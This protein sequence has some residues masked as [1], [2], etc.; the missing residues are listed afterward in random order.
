M[1]VYKQWTTK[2]A[3]IKFFFFFF[4]KMTLFNLY[5]VQ[6][7]KLGVPSHNREAWPGYDFS[8]NRR[9]TLRLLHNYL[10]YYYR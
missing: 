4:K 6:G 8:S 1:V 2:F 9:R 5:Y 10:N 7:S 3:P